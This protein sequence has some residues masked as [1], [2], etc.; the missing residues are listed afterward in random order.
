MSSADVSICCWDAD[1]GTGRVL[2]AGKGPVTAIAAAPHSAHVLSAALDEDPFRALGTEDDSEHSKRKWLDYSGY[3]VVRLHDVASGAVIWAASHADPVERLAFSSDGTRAVGMH[4]R[5]SECSIW[6]V[7][8]VAPLSNL[9][10]DQL[11]VLA[12]PPPVVL[13]RT[14]DRD[15]WEKNEPVSFS[16]DGRA[17]VTNGSFTPLPSPDLWPL[18]AHRQA[19]DD[20]GQQGSAAVGT[21]CAY[22]FSDGWVWRGGPGSQR[23]RVCWIPPEYRP[24]NLGEKCMSSHGHFVAFCTV[25]RRLVLLDFTRCE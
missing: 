20:A 5:S 23:R 7:S 18:S 15:S 1:A 17:I 9:K 24:R 25:D 14:F 22:F 13:I 10:S 16:R 2:Y 21:P 3:A 8:S 19:E 12:A 6:D 11:P 4:W